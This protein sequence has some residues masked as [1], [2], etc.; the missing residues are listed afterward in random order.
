VQLGSALLLL[1]VVPLVLLHHGVAAH[2]EIEN[3][4]ESG[5]AHFSFKRVL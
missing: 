3:N 5:S 4:V 2:V 1:D